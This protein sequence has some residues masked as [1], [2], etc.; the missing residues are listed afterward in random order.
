[1]LF[2]HFVEFTLKTILRDLKAVKKDKNI[3]YNYQKNPLSFHIT[4]VLIIEI[5]VVFL[6]TEFLYFLQNFEGTTLKLV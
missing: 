5:L 1:M 4:D 3:N 6:L 2:S